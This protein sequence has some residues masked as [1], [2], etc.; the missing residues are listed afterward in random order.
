MQYSAISTQAFFQDI[1]DDSK[2]ASLRRRGVIG[3]V[4]PGPIRSVVV[5]VV[6]IHY[7][8]IMIDSIAQQLT[9]LYYMKKT[10]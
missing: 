1:L 4:L 10:Y 3:I 2:H 5:V 7:D 9:G 8:Y 6:E